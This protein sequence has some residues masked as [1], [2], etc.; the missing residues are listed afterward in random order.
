MRLRVTQP[1]FS[2]N[3]AFLP[4]ISGVAGGLTSAEKSREG[5]VDSGLPG[6]FTGA[7]PRVVAG[8]FPGSSPLPRF[9]PSRFR[10]SPDARPP[11]GQPS[12]R[13]APPWPFRG[14]RAP[15]RRS[16]PEPI[17][18]VSPASAP[19][20]FS[21]PFRGPAVFLGASRG[22]KTALRGSRGRPGGIRDGGFPPA[23]GEVCF[24]VFLRP[25][26]FL[27]PAALLAPRR[28]Q[29][30]SQ[31]RGGWGTGFCGLKACT[32][33][34]RGRPGPSPGRSLLPLRPGLF[35]EPLPPSL[36]FGNYIPV[37]P[38]CLTFPAR[39]GTLRS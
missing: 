34:S 38:Q 7:P 11:W 10:A 29:G 35:P 23:A 31:P 14:L 28:S 16:G 6:L 33:G 25:P 21:S 32:G 9:V 17:S 36:F 18:P 30:R 15:G 24:W 37:Y 8:S 4:L 13:P 19:D 39:L 26:A 20:A 5:T 1:P 12:H 2:C 27:P 22:R 3:S